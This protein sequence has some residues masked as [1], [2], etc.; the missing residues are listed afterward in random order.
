MAKKIVLLISLLIIGCSAFADNYRVLYVN[1]EHIRIGNRYIAVGDIFKDTDIIVW[2]SEKQS[3]KVLNLK[4]NR[5]FIC[6]AKSLNKKKS[7]SLYDYLTS[8]KRISTRSLSNVVYDEEWQLDSVLYVLDTL[9]VS[10]PNYNTKNSQPSIVIKSHGYNREIPI[11]FDSRYYKIP[12]EVIKR[13]MASLVKLDIVEYDKERDWKY[14]VYKD[15]IV[16]M[17]PDLVVDY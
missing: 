4:N 12:S 10:R 15:L 8:T 3:M 2:S 5:V 9:Y 17:L 13:S 11:L 1:S 7:H 6:T 14:I 16:E